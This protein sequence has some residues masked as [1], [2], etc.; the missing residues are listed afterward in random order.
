MGNRLEATFGTSTKGRQPLP[1]SLAE[2]SGAIYKTEP[3]DLTGFQDSRSHGDSHILPLGHH[4]LMRRS[5]HLFCICGG[6]EALELTQRK[7]LRV[8][9]CIVRSMSFLNLGGISTHGVECYSWQSRMKRI[10]LYAAGV[11][12]KDHGQEKN[13]PKATS[14]L[15]VHA[16]VSLFTMVHIDITTCSRCLHLLISD[17]IGSRIRAHAPSVHYIGF[18]LPVVMR[19]HGHYA[20][21]CVKMLPL[22]WSHAPKR[23]CTSSK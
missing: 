5:R 13:H 4:Y 15:F 3:V 7:L 2:V 6:P 1:F 14:A 17:Y 11:D 8:A 22:S 19:C 23:A 16:Q 18:Q 21:L 9:P 12:T 10:K 20:M